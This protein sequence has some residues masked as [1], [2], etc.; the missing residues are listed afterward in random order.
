[1]KKSGCIILSFIIASL[2]GTMTVR[3][4]TQPEM[5]AEACREFQTADDEL[6]KTYNQI[7]RIYKADA[8]FIGKLK[9]A[10][11]AWL[12]FRDAHLASIYPNIKPGEYGSVNPMC[13]CEILVD[14]TNERSKALSKWL[15]GVEEGETCAGSIKFKGELDRLT[16]GASK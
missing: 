4:Q 13:R 2:I 11:R 9:T 1:M 10:Q 3:P 6:N 14:L 7:L 15:T 16:R 8:E 5:N 12:A